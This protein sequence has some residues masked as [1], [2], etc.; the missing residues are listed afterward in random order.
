MRIASIL[1]AYAMT[2]V[3]L[4]DDDDRALMWLAIALMLTV[5]LKL[6][7]INDKIGDV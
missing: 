5:L 7:K 6:D 4:W 2:F 3:Y 1:V